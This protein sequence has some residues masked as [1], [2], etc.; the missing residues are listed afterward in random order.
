MVEKK[1]YLFLY[2]AYLSWN[3]KRTKNDMV[4]FLYNYLKL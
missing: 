4:W 1:D 3:I 2:T